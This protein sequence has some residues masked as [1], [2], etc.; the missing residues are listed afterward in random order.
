MTCLRGNILYKSFSLLN[1][2][3]LSRFKVILFPFS[4]RKLEKT[5][6]GQFQKDKSLKLKVNKVNSYFCLSDLRPTYS[7]CPIRSFLDLEVD[8]N[9]FSKRISGNKYFYTF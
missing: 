2:V 7:T 9:R 4:R 5:G 1:Y 6:R 3:F 8:E